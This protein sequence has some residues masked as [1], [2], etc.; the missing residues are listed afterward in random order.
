MMGALS[1]ISV[2]VPVCT[3]DQP[4]SKQLGGSCEM[5][6]LRILR[7]ADNPPVRAIQGLDSGQ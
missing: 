5:A 6:I 4:L 1:S 3:F 7:I 2:R